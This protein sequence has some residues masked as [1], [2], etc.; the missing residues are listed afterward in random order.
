MEVEEEEEEA[1]CRRKESC[2]SCATTP[3]Q[4][5]SCLLYGCRCMTADSWGVMGMFWG[6]LACVNVS[7]SRRLS[8]SGGAAGG[9]GHKRDKVIF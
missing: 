4:C 6:L 9:P 3:P 1:G 2:K 7:G 5:R 8:M